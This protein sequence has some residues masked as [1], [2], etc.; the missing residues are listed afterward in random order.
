MSL[1]EAVFALINYLIPVIYVQFIY[2]IVR[3][4]IYICHQVTEKMNYTAVTAN[5]ERPLQAGHSA[6][7]MQSLFRFLVL[8]NAYYKSSCYGDC[9]KK[10]T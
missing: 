9:I 2:S 4:K 1:S 10:G 3:T 8:L 6:L 5:F 7:F